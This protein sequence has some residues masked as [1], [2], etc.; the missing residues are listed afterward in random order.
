MNERVQ[1]IPRVREDARWCAM[2]R[3]G[4][5]GCARV[6]EVASMPHARSRGATPQGFL[7]K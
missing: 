4:V 1:G 3:E 2:V 5:R 7:S 6:R